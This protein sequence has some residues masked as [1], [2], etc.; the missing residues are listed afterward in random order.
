MTPMLWPALTRLPSA[1]LSSGVN[2][3]RDG[4]TT[5][6]SS[7]PR[8][9]PASTGART[10]AGASGIGDL[11]GQVGGGGDVAKGDVRV[12]S[13][14]QPDERGAGADLDERVGAEVDEG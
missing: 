9:S 5:T 12:G 6:R 3:P 11:Q 13:F 10:R 2:T 1:L 8:T 14:G 7:T 4:A